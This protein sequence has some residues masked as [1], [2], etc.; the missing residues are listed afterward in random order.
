[1]SSSNSPMTAREIIDH[2]MTLTTD[3]SMLQLAEARN[4]L[5]RIGDIVTSPELVEAWGYASEHINDTI[6]DQDNLAKSGTILRIM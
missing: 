3:S 1:M 4:Q 5:N 2:A 6:A